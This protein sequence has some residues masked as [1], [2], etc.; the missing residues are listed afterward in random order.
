MN[1]SGELM[2]FLVDSHFADC[3]LSCV[4]DPYMQQHGRSADSNVV[5]PCLLM[6][7]YEEHLISSDC[8]W[9]S[10]DATFP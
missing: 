8:K 5:Y 1:G 6:P 9:S 4:Q 10:E 7:E 3:C 2:S